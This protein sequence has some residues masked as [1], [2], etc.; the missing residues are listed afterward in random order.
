MLFLVKS[1]RRQSYGQTQTRKSD[2][3]RTGNFTG[4]LAAWAVHGAA[5]NDRPQQK[6]HAGLHFLLKDLLNRAFDGSASAL[7][8]H[9]LQQTKPDSDELDDIRKTIAEFP[10]KKGGA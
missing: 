6:T 2:S 10:R 3:G 8:T 9:L 1:Y 4:Y 5:G 7:V